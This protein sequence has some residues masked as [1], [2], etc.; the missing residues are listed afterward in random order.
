V[1]GY[2][3]ATGVVIPVALERQLVDQNGGIPDAEVELAFGSGS[4][5]VMRVF[6]IDMEADVCELWWIAE[7]YEGRI[8]AGFVAI[9]DDSG[10]NLFLLNVADHDAQ[11]WYWN[12]EEG[13][14]PM[15]IGRTLDEFVRAL[16]EGT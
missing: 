9:A 14:A 13:L 11:V 2:A 8:P 6:G 1:H 15:P 4:T 5:D 3:S 16:A 12:H 10:G 7:T